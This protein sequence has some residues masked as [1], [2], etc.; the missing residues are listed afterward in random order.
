MSEN[1]A[2]AR[3]T[4]RWRRPVQKEGEGGR[5]VFRI[6]GLGLHFPGGE[7][8][9]ANLLERSR[10]IGRLRDAGLTGDEKLTR[11]GGKMVKRTSRV[12]RSRGDFNSFRLG[13]MGN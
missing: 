12:R 7:Y 13:S 8:E 3:D 1:L 2:S 5:L 10:A 6:E 11:R 9:N 4:C